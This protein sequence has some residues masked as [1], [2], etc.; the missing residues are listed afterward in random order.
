MI[1]YLQKKEAFRANTKCF[2][3]TRES[4]GLAKNKMSKFLENHGIKKIG[5]RSY[6][7]IENGEKEFELKKFQDI[8]NAFNKEFAKKNIDKRIN[9]EDLYIS[10]I[11]NENII[12]KEKNIDKNS[13]A[14]LYEIETASN[15]MWHLDRATK[16]KTFGL[17]GMNL[18]VEEDVN[19]LFGW[20]NSYNKSLSKSLD[21]E[22][23]D[24]FNV[25][26]EVL[27]ISTGI[28][29][30]LKQLAEKNMKLYCGIISLPLIDYY[31]KNSAIDPSNLEIDPAEFGINVSNINYIIY[32]FS[33]EGEEGIK[34]IYRN[35]FSKVELEEITKNFYHQIS[36]KELNNYDKVYKET[37][38]EVK[39][40][41][42]NHKQIMLPINFDRSKVSFEPV[43]MEIDDIPF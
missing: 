23:L 41:F 39:T 28:N 42:F 29:S 5:Q 27:D 16:K 11:N 35:T 37:L 19:N 3:Q 2:V 9:P 6:L 33:T 38:N 30:N 32:Y 36:L 4:L 15:L 20:I 17:S 22:Q 13:Y 12:S 8:A 26:K 14:N 1:K 21:D 10:K 25:E 34:V 24:D 31:N 18:S 7:R 43:Y 40:S